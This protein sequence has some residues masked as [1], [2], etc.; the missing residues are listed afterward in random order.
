VDAATL[1][2]PLPPLAEQS[3]ICKFINRQVARIDSLIAEQEKLLALLAEKR[4]ATI[5]HAVTRG[6]DPNVPM[7]DSGIDWLGEVPAHWDVVRLRRVAS[8]NP[9]KTE[10]ADT[11]NPDVAFLPM[12][13]IGEDGSIRREMERPLADLISGYSYFR[14]QDVVVAKITPCFENGK[15]ALI[16]DLPLGYGFGTTELIV[17][18]SG[19]RLRPGFLW[20]AL[21]SPVFRR[22]AEGAMYGAG[23][24]K[25]VPDEFVRD[26][27]LCVPP[28][29]EQ[30]A[31]VNAVSDQLSR[32]AVLRA[33]A[34]G[35]I[36]LLGERRAA[37]ISAAVTGQIDV[38]GL[39]SEEAA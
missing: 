24:Q 1:E 29:D 7:K 10:I 30:E 18:R 26:Y 31:V 17:V 38:R 11:G 16:A 28:L 12:D 39:L 36:S 33:K 4:Q 15:G 35:A 21:S 20:L 9:S 23:G 14:N 22:L 34:E 32:F 3:A 19:T 37:L 6:L 5:S 25:R 8:L 27:P 2:L 13:A